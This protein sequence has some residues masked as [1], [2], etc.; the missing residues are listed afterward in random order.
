[1]DEEAQKAKKIK[2]LRKKKWR[3]SYIKRMGR[4]PTY[5][6]LDL[7][8]YNGL[9]DYVQD[10]ND[11]FPESKLSMTKVINSRLRGYLQLKGYCDAVAQEP[12]EAI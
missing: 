1:M 12:K 2:K 7:D 9:K 6:Y 3:E 11:K 4:R 8:L 10:Q 5:L